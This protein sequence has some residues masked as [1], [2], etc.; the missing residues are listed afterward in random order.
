MEQFRLPQVRERAGKEGTEPSP[1]RHRNPI[2]FGLHLDDVDQPF[3]FVTE[4]VEWR[5]PH[6]AHAKMVYRG[7]CGSSLGC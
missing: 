3:T 6:D 4:G 1:I 2:C 5:P 7:G